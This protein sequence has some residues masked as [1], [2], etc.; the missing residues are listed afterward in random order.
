[1]LRPSLLSLAAAALATA[2][3][4][5]CKVDTGDTTVLVLHN[6]APQLGCVLTSD[7][8]SGF[9]AAGTLDLYNARIN[10]I[11][12]ITRGYF[13]TPLAENLAVADTTN[14][15]Q[16]GAKTFVAQ[17][18][19]VDITFNNT[20]VLSA[21][22]QDQLASQ[23]LTHFD[24]RFSGA[25]QPNGGLSTFGFE[26]VPADIFNLILMKNP[27]TPGT[28]YVPIGD[29]QM[30]IDIRLFGLMGG[31]THESLDFTYPVTVCDTCLI[32]NVGLCSTLMSGFIARTGGF[33]D[34][35]QDGVT[36][37]CIDAN[38]NLLCPAMAPT[39]GA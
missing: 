15:Q 10:Q 28:P 34:S 23:G 36:D 29:V 30:L 32:D 24:A 17:G 4:A 33:C 35:D 6:Q 20:D 16:V 27:H 9:L 22:D 5:G 8:T 21:A 7:M 18:A 26:A 19:H 2:A 13:L 1:M 39:G 14:L 11:Q 38:N 3:I 31:D 25:I 37:C 12:R